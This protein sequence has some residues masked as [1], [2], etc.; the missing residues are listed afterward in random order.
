MKNE[1]NKELFTNTPALPVDDVVDERSGK[2]KRAE[3]KEQR[4]AFKESLSD[5]QKAI[6]ENAELSREEKKDAL[7]ETLTDEQKAQMEEFKRH[8]HNHKKNGGR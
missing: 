5:D 4:Q 8:K 7:S 3:N 6:I 1:T 2:Q